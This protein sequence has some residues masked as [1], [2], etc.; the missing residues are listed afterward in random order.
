MKSRAWLVVD[1]SP[2]RRPRRRRSFV[3]RLF[4]AFELLAIHPPFGID[5]VQAHDYWLPEDLAKLRRRTDRRDYEPAAKAPSSRPAPR[6]LPG[7]TRDASRQRMA[8][9]SRRDG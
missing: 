5:P 2:A 9:A 4:K 7:L 8:S 6:R 3:E 1:V